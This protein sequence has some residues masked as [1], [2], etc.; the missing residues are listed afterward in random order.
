MFPLIK[1]AKKLKGSVDRHRLVKS[2]LLFPLIKLAKK[3][4]VFIAIALVIAIATTPRFPLIKLAKKLKDILDT[5]TSHQSLAA[6]F[7]LIKLAKKLKVSS[8]RSCD[9]C[10]R[11]PKVSIN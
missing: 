11:N 1:L 8:Y 3:L 10:C 9:S 4:K 5:L 7:P 6:R 2:N